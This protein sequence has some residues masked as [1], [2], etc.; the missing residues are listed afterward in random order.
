VAIESVA[1]R[2]VGKRVGVDSAALSTSVAVLA[3]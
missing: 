1:Y 3:G 2:S